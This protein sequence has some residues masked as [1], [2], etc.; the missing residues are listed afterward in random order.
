V[1]K[2]LFIGVGLAV[3]VS[4]LTF[5][6]AKESESAPAEMM[7]KMREGT[8]TPGQ[9]MMMGKGQMMMGK[10][11]MMMCP[12]HQMMA[13]SMMTKSM[14]ATEDEGIVVMAG[15][16]L[17]KFDKDLNLVKETLLPIDTEA[18]QKK[19]TQTMKSCPMCCPMM[20]AGS[21]MEKA[22]AK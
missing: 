4:V 22:P 5:S 16:K 2:L 1:K 15:E 7:R 6:F 11:Q 17:M 14:V 10:G 9:E 20:Q 21:T 18:M 19:M 13:G 3:L 12:M 8:A